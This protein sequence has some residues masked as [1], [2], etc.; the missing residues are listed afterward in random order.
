MFIE[1]L[2]YLLGSRKF[3]VNET[4]RNTTPKKQTNKKVL[5]KYMFN[6]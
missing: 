4:V 2:N 5:I 3:K 1:Y 6:N